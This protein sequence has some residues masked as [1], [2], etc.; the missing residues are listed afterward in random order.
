MADFEK[1]PGD[2]RASVTTEMERKYETMAAKLK[3]DSLAINPIGF[4]SPGMLSPVDKDK[5]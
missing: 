5:H 2:T 4:I 3:Q 1:A